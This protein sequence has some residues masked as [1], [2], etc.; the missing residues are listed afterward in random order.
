MGSPD[1]DAQARVS[2]EEG[3]IRWRPYLSSL[4]TEDPCTHIIEPYIPTQRTFLHTADLCI[5]WILHRADLYTPGP[6][7]ITRSI[8]PK[9]EVR[10]LLWF[11]FA[12]TLER[13]P[14]SFCFSG[15]LAS[16][17]LHHVTGI[18]QGPWIRFHQS[19]SPAC[20]YGQ[21]DNA[22]RPPGCCPQCV[23]PRRDSSSH[24]IL[25]QLCGLRDATVTAQGHPG[26]LRTHDNTSRAARTSQ[27][28]QLG[29]TWS[30]N[31]G[32]LSWHCHSRDVYAVNTSR[33]VV[34]SPIIAGRTQGT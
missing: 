8:G 14:N 9:V 34:V 4:A 15:S 25:E 16:Q 30:L 32:P 17:T 21:K 20:D 27:K 18:S 11:L 3:G 24:K 6:R 23:G 19:Q 22:V 2:A 12:H 28:G 26:R 31:Q 29:S 5:Q 1:T 10:L 13:A 7:K 33:S